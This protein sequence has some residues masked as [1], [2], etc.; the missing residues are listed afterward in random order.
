MAR[1]RGVTMLELL[2]VVVIV[3]IITAFA[4]PSYMQYVVSTKRTAAT[5]TLMQIAE[6]QQQFF[7]DNKSYTNDL[8]NLGYAANPLSINDS[9]NSVAA[10]DGDSVYTITLSNITATTYTATAAPLQGQLSRDTDCG[11]LT[12][13]Q[14]GA[15]GNSAGGEGCW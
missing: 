14:A 5:V 6:R 3:A 2:I 10:G 13:N 11:S 7:M 9:G 12:L 1:Q 4:Y 8:T 15:R